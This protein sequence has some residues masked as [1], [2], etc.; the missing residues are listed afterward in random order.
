MKN[1]IVAFGILLVAVLLGAWLLART[2]GD[3]GTPET[4]TTT[5]RTY[6]SET[7]G[8]SF[9]YPDPYTLE[10]RDTGNGERWRHVITLM[11][12]A[13]L[14]PPIDGEGPPSIEIAFYQN[15]LDKR[16][17]AEWITGTNDSNFKLGP[18]T[19]ASTTVAGRAALR[20]RWSGLYEGVTTAFLAG[21]AIVAVSASYLE[22]GDEILEVY[23]DVLNSIQFLR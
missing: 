2:D 7:Y 19:Y 16:T 3:G 14:P 20:Y 6:S 18:G 11:R 12:K 17:V 8:I 21:D 22:P 4:A 5:Q 1:W 23:E 9:Q 10:E 15:N 13:D